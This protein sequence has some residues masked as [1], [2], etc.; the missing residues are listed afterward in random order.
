MT[1]SDGGCFET[2]LAV[3][4]GWLS[5]LYTGSADALRSLYL[6][7]RFLALPP[8]SPIH[9]D[10]LNHEYEFNR[11]R[12]INSRLYRRKCL[13]HSHRSEN[14]RRIPCSWRW[15]L[16]GV[17]SLGAPKTTNLSL[18]TLK[19]SC[20]L[21]RFATQTR[22]TGLYLVIL[23]LRRSRPGR[24]SLEEGLG[25]YRAEVDTRLY[26]WKHQNIGI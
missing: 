15:S 17:A 11:F 18:M 23:D 9:I 14:P 21:D 22:F 1:Q 5:H 26:Y 4:S 10:Q 25:W 3:W 16:F 8:P 7:S 6:T 12:L 2:M 20:S 13:A 19:A 24:C